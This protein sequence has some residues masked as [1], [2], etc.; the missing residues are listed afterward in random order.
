MRILPYIIPKVFQK[1]ALGQLLKHF[2]Y[3]S[4]CF[5][6]QIHANELPR[7]GFFTQAELLYLQAEESGLSYAVESSSPSNLSHSKAKNFNFEWDV[8]FNVGIGYRVPHDTWQL[9]LQF[10]SLQTHADSLRKTS[11]GKFFFP[12]WL[13][14]THSDRLF[15]DQVKAHWRLHF[16]LMDLLLSKSYHPTPTLTLIPQIGIRWGSARQKLNLEYRG[17]NFPP[18]EDV[19]VRMK[20]KFSGIGPLL[21]LTCE[22]AFPL[23]FSLFAKGAISALYGDFY[24]H[25]DEDT[26]GT[27]EKLLGLHSVFRATSPILE[28]TLGIQW[29]HYFSGTLKRLTLALA[30]DELLLFSQNQLA[31]FVDKNQT[32]IT[33]ANQGDLSIAGASFHIAFDF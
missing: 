9:L 26:F 10:T 32:G 2:G 12:L 8:G 15:V 21:G 14:P 16:G 3:T 1:L 23:E 5:F 18:G 31:R 7:K 13:G 20:N 4:F 25:Q 17:G 30:W 22:Y 11:G 24:L 6:L 29:Q 27:K 28:G 19:S 33:V